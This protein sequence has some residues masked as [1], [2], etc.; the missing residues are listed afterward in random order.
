MALTSK[1]PPQAYTRD[2]LVKAIEWLSGQPSAVRERAS[3][4]DLIVSHYLQARRQHAAT[5]VEQAPIS[6]ESFK[7]DLKHLAEDMKQFEEP[8]APPPAPNRAPSYV[9]DQLETI[10]NHHR[11]DSL[12]RHELTRQERQETRTPAP[13]PISTP[14]PQMRTTEMTVKGVAWNVD[15]RSLS[16]AREL[17]EA[18]NLSSEGEAL[19]MLVSLGAERVKGLIS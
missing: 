12:F 11:Q 5:A 15:A 8:S 13:T 7:A 18:L 17:Q 4:A 10:V 2:T 16:V 6:Q 1:L 3:S 9:R 14:E 19:R